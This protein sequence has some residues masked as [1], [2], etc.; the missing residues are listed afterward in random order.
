M[1]YLFALISTAFW[2]VNL[3]LAR[4][5]NQA[6]DP[7]SLAFLRWLVAVIVFSPFALPTVI[8]NRRTIRRNLPYL[9]VTG[10]FGVTL[11]NTLVY[12][13][14]RSTEAINL[15]LI[16]MTFPIFVLLLSRVFLREPVGIIR[17]LGVAVVFTGLLLLV[18]DGNVEVLLS[19]SFTPGDLL[20]LVA[21]LVFATY[22]MLVRRRPP[23]LGPI[24][25]QYATFVFGLLYL[26]PVFVGVR[27]L[28][29]PL[30]LTLGIAAAILYVG[31]CASLLA[32]LTWNRA[33]ALLG[34]GK[35][36]VM[37]YTL[38]IFSGL[39]A[40]LA[41]GEVFG[42][43]HLVSLVLIVSGILM[44]TRAPVRRKPAV[45]SRPG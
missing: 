43:L 38:P 25:F 4:A 32:F 16:T 9:L 34:P 41:L 33:I 30:V 20:V 11:F 42:I 5:L 45:A 3:V 13:A 26:T 21:S 10:L 19:L 12:F 7:I 35:A 24:S 31:V 17:A 2:S 15:S 27:L 6:I 37:Y 39:L 28:G 22:S 23:E 36:S 1:G 18:S 8:R 40:W 44:A 29:P 14:G